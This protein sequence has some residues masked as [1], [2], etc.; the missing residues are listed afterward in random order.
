MFIQHDYAQRGYEII[1]NNLRV[2]ELSV[3]LNDLAP[4]QIANPQ[5]QYPPLTVAPVDKRTVHM[6]RTCRWTCCKSRHLCSVGG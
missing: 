1:F 6:I 5:S 4:T 3:P 2:Q